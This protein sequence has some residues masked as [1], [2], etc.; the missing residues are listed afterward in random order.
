MKSASPL[1][2][3]LLEDPLYLRRNQFPPPGGRVERDPVNTD[4]APAK[5]TILLSGMIASAPRQGGA[6]WA[7]LQYLLGLRRLGHE[8]YFVEPVEQG[9]LSPAGTSLTRSENASYFR[10][11]VEGFGLE[12]SAS[13]LLAGTR[14]TVGLSY[15]GLR[16]AARRADL[17]I[18]VSGMLTDENL[19]G[20][21]PARAYLDIDPAFNQLW[22]AAQ[23][24]DMRFEGHTHFVTIGL[25][26]GL[27]DC[28]V[29][30]CGREWVKTLQPVVIEHWPVAD[31]VSY[32]ALT[33]VGNW[34]AYGSIEHEGVFYGQKVHSIREFIR[35]PTLTRE[36]FLL[37]LAIHPQETRDLAALENNGWK[38]IDPAGVAH[39]PW[40]YREFIQH[41]KAEFGIAKSGYVNS[42]CGWF[43]DR[44]ICYLASG[45]PVIAQETGFSRFLPAGEGLF[46]FETEADVVAAVE[47][48]NKDYGRHSVAARAVAEEFFESDK[49]LSGLLAK[50][51]LAA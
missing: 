30:T 35:L 34:R 39:D 37:A 29:P 20:H 38:L 41:S 7:V 44:S 8:V 21:I 4:M 2:P 13:L 11:V 12:A 18:N 50:L 27:P 24:I 23:G 9:A 32:R 26:I 1:N 33:T 48:M 5:L 3:P 40:S 47:E 17:L 22:Q 6:T 16:R 36:P 10:K 42:R 25:A 28:P 15:D 14:E 31:S 45:R 51:G 49:V 19:L 46:S 43:S